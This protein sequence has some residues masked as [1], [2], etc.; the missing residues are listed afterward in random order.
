MRIAGRDPAGLAAVEED[1]REERR[2]AGDREA[3]RQRVDT[4]EDEA[5]VGKSGSM[6]RSTTMI[7][8]DGHRREHRERR[9]PAP[10]IDAREVADAAADASTAAGRGS[11]SPRPRRRGSRSRIATIAATSGHR[12]WKM[13]E[14]MNVP[15][16]PRLPLI[17][18]AAISSFG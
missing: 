5:V 6:S 16:S 9:R 13:Y 1:D 14:L 10:A 17:P 15:G 4:G 18:N 2:D 7:D 11:R 12:N 3:E 8:A